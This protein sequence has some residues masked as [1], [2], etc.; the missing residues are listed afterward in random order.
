MVGVDPAGHSLPALGFAFAAAA[1]RGIPLVAVRGWRRDAPADLEGICGSSIAAEARAADELEQLLSPW[2]EVFPDVPVRS[3]LLDAELEAAL[4]A[5]S[6]GAALLVVGCRG[7]RIGPGPGPGAIRRVAQ[8]AHAPV[9]VV[10]DGAARQAP[11]PRA[12]RRAPRS[13]RSVGRMPWK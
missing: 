4:S 1:Q 10:P 6:R 8:R 12:R 2:R 7:R 9:I 13:D 3:W 11:G 5:E